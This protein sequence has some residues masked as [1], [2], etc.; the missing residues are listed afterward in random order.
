MTSFDVQLIDGPCV[1]GPIEPFPSEGGAECVFIGRTR[2]ETHPEHGALTRLSYD[3]YRPMAQRVL[4]DLARKAND[5]WPCLVV[6]L[7]HAVGDVP[8]GGA[9][10]VVQ[11]AA[12]H[13]AEAFAAGRWLIDTLKQKAPIWKQETWADG[14]TWSTGAPVTESQSEVD[15]GE[16]TV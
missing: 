8:V 9:S 16:A 2:A 4:E 14:T 7:H 6:R 10:V 3:A 13:R 5:R 15:S 1:I 12:G 11:V